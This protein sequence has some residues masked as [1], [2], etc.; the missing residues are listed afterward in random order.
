M[1]LEPYVLQAP[2]EDLIPWAQAWLEIASRREIAN[3]M[4]DRF[5]AAVP[6]TE[7]LPPLID[8]ASARVGEPQRVRMEAIP[9]D[10]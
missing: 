10:S 7:L 5:R 2:T 4:P 1:P 3:R 9:L 6:M 8:V